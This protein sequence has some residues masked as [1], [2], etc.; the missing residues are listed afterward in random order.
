MGKEITHAADGKVIL[1]PCSGIDEF[2][3]S[4][5]AGPVSANEI[6]GERGGSGSE[7]HE[8]SP[9][10]QNESTSVHCN[11]SIERVDTRVQPEEDDKGN[12]AKE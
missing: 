1:V 11:V 3:V 6:A 9:A 8:V 10:G 2:S 4:G 7:S 12:L 5:E